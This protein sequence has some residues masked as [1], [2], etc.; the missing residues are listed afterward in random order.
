MRYDQAR[1]DEADS[2]ITSLPRLGELHCPYRLNMEAL[3][4]GQKFLTADDTE[5]PGLLTK[6][7]AALAKAIGHVFLWKGDSSLL[8]ALCYG[9]GNN[10]LRGVRRGFLPVSCTATAM[11]WL[12]ANQL[13]CRKLG[14]GEDSVKTNLLLLDAGL[15]HGYAPDSWPP[16]L[17]QSLQVHGGPAQL[18]AA[19]LERARKTGHRLDIAHCL[20]RQMW[21]ASSESAA[22]QPFLD[23]SELYMELGRRDELASL[24]IEWHD[25]FGH[26]EPGSGR[27]TNSR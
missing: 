4:A 5:A 21:L 9:F 23:A 15:E 18:L 25:R 14:I 24:C 26:T 13:A 22:R 6:A 2:L 7:L 3:L 1:Y 10:I 20:R 12:A 8:D 11:Q 27:G 19:S 16:L 17:R